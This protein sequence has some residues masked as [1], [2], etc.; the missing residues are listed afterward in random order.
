MSLDRSGLEIL[1]AAE[2]RSLL[3]ATA[4]GRIVFTERALPAIQPVKYAL[5]GGDVVIR[6]STGSKLADATRDAVVAFEADAFDASADTGWSV[7][8]IGHA[9]EVTDP[10]E[11]AALEALPLRPWAGGACDRFI[12][13]HPELVSGRRIP[14]GGC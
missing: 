4:L 8:V 7:V 6:T 10:D 5:I 1:D 12:R 11:Q 3:N 14:E 13:I 2:C 9:H